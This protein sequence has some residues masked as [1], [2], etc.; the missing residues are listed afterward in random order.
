MK[1]QSGP[2]MPEP[3]QRKETRTE[4]LDRELMAE[5]SKLH[6]FVN[7]VR[8]N[9]SRYVVRVERKADNTFYASVSGVGRV[10]RADA[11]TPSAA[12]SKVLRAL[13]WGIS[14]WSKQDRH[15]RSVKEYLGVTR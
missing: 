2:V 11:R 12:V 1:T 5:R 10:F 7:A 9:G 3:Y 8:K 4:R 13:E 6:D 14:E 15:Q